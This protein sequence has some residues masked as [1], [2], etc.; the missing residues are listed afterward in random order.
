MAPELLFLNLGHDK[1]LKTLTYR[2]KP[3]VLDGAS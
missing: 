2:V 3:K 1:Q